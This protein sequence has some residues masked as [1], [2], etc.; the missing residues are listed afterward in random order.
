MG[1]ERPWT[2]EAW[3]RQTRRIL[4]SYAHWIGE[5]L[6]DRA[7][8]LADDSENL[9]HAPFVVVSHGTQ[10]DPILNYGNAQALAL[11]EMDLETLLQTPS[12]M[13]AEPVHRDERA[14]LLKRTTENGYVDDY[15]GIR[16]SSTGRRFFIKRATVWN[17][18]DESG[19]NAGQ[20]ATFSEWT[21]V[22]SR[23]LGATS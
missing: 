5:Q 18:L 23:S 22:D 2:D 4:D 3:I 6:I 21:E 9:F 16:I 15:T 11:W 17:L 20:A 14:Q 1:T 13:T 7:A 8:S 12:R 10:A 19:A